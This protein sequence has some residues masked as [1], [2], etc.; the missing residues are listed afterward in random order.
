MSDNVMVGADGKVPYHGKVRLLRNLAPGARSHG[1]PRGEGFGVLGALAGCYA[2]SSPRGF[3]RKPTRQKVA[4]RMSSHLGSAVG[5]GGVGERW[6][7]DGTGSVA[8]H[9][10]DVLTARVGGEERQL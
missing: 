6:R 10:S 7:L 9:Y 8:V 5:A 2:T 3:G 4:W 1:C